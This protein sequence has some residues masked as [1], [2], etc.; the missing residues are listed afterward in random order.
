MVQ[1]ERLWPWFWI[2]GSEVEFVVQQKNFHNH[3]LNRRLVFPAS[4]QPVLNSLWQGLC[5]VS[6]TTSDCYT[7]GHRCIRWLADEPTPKHR[8]NW[9]Y[10]VEFWPLQHLWTF[11]LQLHRRPS[12]TPMTMWRI[13]RCPSVDLVQTL[14]DLGQ[15]CSNGYT[16][17]QISAL[18]V[19]PV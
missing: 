19:L 2:F 18:S 14:S 11:L 8:L 3:R 1:I 12:D 6:G 9:C 17:A 15:N 13:F 5:I 7:D 4:V 10:C 16:D